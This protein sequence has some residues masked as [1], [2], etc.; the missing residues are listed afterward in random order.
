VT[1]DGR[2]KVGDRVAGLV[3]SGGNARFIRVSQD[4]LVPVPRNLD[5]SEA[6]CMVSIYAAAYQSV[7]AAIV[8]SSSSSS[9][10]SASNFSL[11]GKK[12]LV[13][14]GMDGTGQAIIQIC[15]KARADV[16]CTA[17]EHRH[18]YVRSTMGAIPLP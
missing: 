1:A 18:A 6:V 13:I 14:G 5:T 17:P 10:S 11:P 8:S 7:K 15:R 12:V 16:Y 3:R 4:N 2:F 9:S